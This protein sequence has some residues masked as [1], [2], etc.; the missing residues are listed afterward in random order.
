MED[1]FLI[2]QLITTFK[3]KLEYYSEIT[4]IISQN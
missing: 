2:Q 4:N 1:V 3:I